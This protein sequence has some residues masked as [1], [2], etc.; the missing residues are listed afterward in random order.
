MVTNHRGP[1]LLYKL[2]RQVSLPSQRIAACYT[3]SWVLN[4][5]RSICE[6]RYC[7]CNSIY[8]IEKIITTT[9]IIIIVVIIIIEIPPELSLGCLVD[10][11]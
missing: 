2:L 7:T 6:W 10:S 11:P 9:I 1:R 4:I 8:N 5:G 3:E